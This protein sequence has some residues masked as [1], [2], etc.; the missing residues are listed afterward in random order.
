MGD[1]RI[2]IT[3]PAGTVV[4]DR[5]PPPKT[6]SKPAA[7]PMSQGNLGIEADGPSTAADV[8]LAKL[9]AW[10]ALGGFNRERGSNP[11]E[12]LRDFNDFYLNASRGVKAALLPEFDAAHYLT[13]ADTCGPMILTKRRLN[14]SAREGLYRLNRAINDKDAPIA[15]P[16]AAK[17]VIEYVSILNRR[18]MELLGKPLR[19][20]PPNAI[21]SIKDR[22]II[23]D[24]QNR[25][26]S[27]DDEGDDAI[28]CLFALAD[29]RPPSI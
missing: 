3:P 9:L 13:S 20:L 23:Q 6:P 25:I 8:R 10:N 16:L 7:K 4:A 2:T 22:S 15:K 17:L 27:S 19:D 21:L 26:W 24:L 14:D 18:S 12:D 28:R 11:I 1:G 29:G 5:D